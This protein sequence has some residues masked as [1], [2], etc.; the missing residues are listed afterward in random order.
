MKQFSIKDRV[1]IP[2]GYVGTIVEEAPDGQFRISVKG[3]RNYWYYQEDLAHWPG[4]E[5]EE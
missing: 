5:E 1:T 2:E 4:E 3:H